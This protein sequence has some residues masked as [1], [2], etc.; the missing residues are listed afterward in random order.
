MK[1]GGD[2]ISPLHTIRNPQVK[3]CRQEFRWARCRRA[4]PQLRLRTLGVPLPRDELEDVVTGLRWE[5]IKVSRP[6]RR[7][8]WFGMLQHSRSPS[9]RMCRAAVDCLA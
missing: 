8:M 5:D 6:T 9:L 2:P 4:L 1:S 7:C 3:L